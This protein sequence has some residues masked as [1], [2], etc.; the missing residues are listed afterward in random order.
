MVLGRWL[1]GFSAFAQLRDERGSASPLTQEQKDEGGT[2]C[3]NKDRATQDQAGVG[4]C[5]AVVLQKL[6]QS[7]QLRRAR[8]ATACNR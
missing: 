7:S 1:A 4:T 8:Q 6:V 5:G 3:P 2:E